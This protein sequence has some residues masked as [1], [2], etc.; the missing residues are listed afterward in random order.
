MPAFCVHNQ[1]LK[2]VYSDE[3]PNEELEVTSVS[4]EECSALQPDSMF[5][6]VFIEQRLASLLGQAVDDR[7]WLARKG[8]LISSST[9]HLK[10]LRSRSPNCSRGIR[11]RLRSSRANRR[12]LTVS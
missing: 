5:G 10:S 3:N 6:H 4:A 11:C 9:C 7:G 8:A 12:A 2:V 1:A